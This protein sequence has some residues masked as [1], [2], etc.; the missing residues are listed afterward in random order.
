M[1]SAKWRCIKWKLSILTAPLGFVA[2]YALS[3]RENSYNSFAPKLQFIGHI[4]S[5]CHLRPMFIQSRMY[6][7]KLSLDFSPKLCLRLWY[8]YSL[9]SVLICI[10]PSHLFSYLDLWLQVCL[11]NSVFCVPLYSLVAFTQNVL[12]HWRKKL[13][14]HE[15][16]Q[17]SHQAILTISS[18]HHVVAPVSRLGPH[19]S[20]ELPSCHL[21][22][23]PSH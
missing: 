20:T 23:L 22:S 14:V 1:I 12:W 17:L 19:R 5:R 11:I 2:S 10:V 3:P 4:F 15:F 16:P 7:N 9:I 21:R 13:T 6:F 8:I 18:A